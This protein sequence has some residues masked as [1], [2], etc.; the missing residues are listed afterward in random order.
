M[1]KNGKI[2]VVDYKQSLIKNNSSKKKKLKLFQNKI[3]DIIINNER[4]DIHS[5]IIYI[6]NSNFHRKSSLS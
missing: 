6:Y 2:H 5:N 4:N 3:N 1:D